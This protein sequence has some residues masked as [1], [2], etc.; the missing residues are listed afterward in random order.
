MHRA[1]RMTR[2]GAPGRAWVLAVCCTVLLGFRRPISGVHVGAPAPQPGPAS[3]LTV[4]RV[5][6]VATHAAP[7]PAQPAAFAA[8]ALR[9]AAMHPPATPQHQV[10]AAGAHDAAPAPLQ[11]HSV[12]R[13]Q[14]PAPV[15]LHAVA[16]AVPAPGASR[17]HAPAVAGPHAAA[18]ETL[19]PGVT[20]LHEAAAAALAPGAEQRRAPRPAEAPAAAAMHLRRSASARGPARGPVPE[21]VSLLARRGGTPDG[22]PAT[23]PSLVPADIP[24]RVDYAAAAAAA[25]PWNVAHGHAPAAPGTPA[26]GTAAS[27]V[28]AAPSA[29]G[30]APDPGPLTSSGDTAYVRM[31][32]DVSGGPDLGA[33]AAGEAYAAVPAGTRAP[34]LAADAGPT[35]GSLEVPAHSSSPVTYGPAHALVF[36]VLLGM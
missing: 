22:D 2:V 17:L 23:A 21:L 15:D 19:A 27:G 9:N 1:L 24:L 35:G 16:A 34:N 11:Q 10:L 14:A 28:A 30:G 29:G 20:R 13:W 6:E 4:G 3:Y 12:M 7:A 26:A 32:D 31:P 8:A 25:T 18:T 33:A 5:E 36:H